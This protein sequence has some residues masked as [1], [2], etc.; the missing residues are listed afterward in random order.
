[1]SDTAGIEW[2][3]ETTELPKVAHSVLL[4]TPRQFDEFWDIRHAQL[5]IG[6]EGVVPG[7][8]PAGSRWR[9]DQYWQ[10]G[11]RQGEIVLITGNSWWSHINQI[12]LPP[13][14]EHRTR[15]GQHLIVKAD[16]YKWIP[17]RPR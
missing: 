4:A 6:H 3:S 8:I 10:V 1:M 17:G 13:G 14:A 9:S 5:L 15:N 2:I 11:R 12:P 16:G 7:P